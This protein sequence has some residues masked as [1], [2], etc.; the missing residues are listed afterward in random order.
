MSCAETCS[1]ILIAKVNWHR[2]L[3]SKGGGAEAGPVAR[4]NLA[5]E[6]RLGWALSSPAGNGCD[7]P[8]IPHRSS[9][10]LSHG[11]WQCRQGL[12]GDGEPKAPGGSPSR[13]RHCE[14]RSGTHV[15]EGTSWEPQW[16]EA[17]RYGHRRL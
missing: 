8:A 11:R 5:P 4:S 1:S 16:W 10:P 7:D 2:A 13:P 12:G 9:R 17:A 3:P 15:S 6:P 14:K